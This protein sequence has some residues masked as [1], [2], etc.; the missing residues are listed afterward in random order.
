M[1]WADVL[2]GDAN[3]NGEKTNKGPGEHDL[4]T[5][6]NHLCKTYGA[7]LFSC[8]SVYVAVFLKDLA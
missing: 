5:Q 7:N 4:K 2:N 8:K 6:M 3:E 1:L